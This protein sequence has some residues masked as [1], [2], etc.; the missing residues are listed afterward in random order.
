MNVKLSIAVFLLLSFFNLGAVTDMVNEQKKSF[1]AIEADMRNISEFEE[2][3]VKLQYK[4][5]EDA[6]K[7]IS[8]IKRQL[9]NNNDGNYR[10][11]SK[12][13]FE[14]SR[15]NFHI[16]IKTWEE[17]KY[18]YFEIKVINK[19][20]K[21]KTLYLKDMLKKIEDEKSYDEQ[22]FLYYKGK[23]IKGDMDYY[24]NKLSNEEGIQKTNVLE[25]ANGYAGI[26]DLSDGERINFALIRYDTGSNIIIGTPTI[27]EL[28]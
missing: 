12:K 1:G 21:Y 3:G 9:N 6:Q 17:D 4:T 24:L 22:Y 23:K 14:I 26:G 11:I 20:P 7:E 13:Q 8:K 10:E 2:N 28:Y 19:N 16:D 25:I 27:F 18:N 5:R 15:D